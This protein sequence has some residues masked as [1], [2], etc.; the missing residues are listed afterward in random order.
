MY[1]IL[2]SVIAM[3]ILLRISVTIF[4]VF[5]IHSCKNYEDDIIK[6][7]DGNIYTSVTIGT[8]VWM[9]ENLKTTK[10][11][12]GTA[13]S[14]VTDNTAWNNLKTPGY[15]WQNN[16]IANKITYGA[17]YNWYAVNTDKLCPTGWHVPSNTEWT[18]LTTNLGGETVSG[19]KL[20]EAGTIH[21]D[22]PNTGATNESKF[23]ALPGGYRPGGN[24]M[25]IGTTGYW[26]SSTESTAT[27]ASYLI[28]W[29]TFSSTAISSVIKTDG[30]SVRCLKD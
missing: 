28:M 21:W 27:N 15:C 4:S 14:L 10:Y 12:Y 20:K 29:C 23:T 25:S 5:L 9:V 22:S 16:D 19:G 7:V 8:Q 1:Q 18:T 30:M 26:W 17:L 13:I 2:L 3:K 6:D 24:F 11:N